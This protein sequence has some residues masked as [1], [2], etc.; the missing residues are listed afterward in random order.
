MTHGAF[1]QVAEGDIPGSNLCL[2]HS[3]N[4]FFFFHFKVELTYT[5]RPQGGSH[6][7]R[8]QPQTALISSLWEESDCLPPGRGF[9]VG[10]T[11]AWS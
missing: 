4:V 3:P 8:P 11:G 5:W 9:W 2:N 10:C 1:A 6:H 7:N